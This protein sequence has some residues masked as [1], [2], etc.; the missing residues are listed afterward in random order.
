MAYKACVCT[1]LEH[2]ATSEGYLYLS[3]QNHLTLPCIVTRYV[4]IYR[5]P[6]I[7]RGMYISRLSM[8]LG[9]SRL[10]FRG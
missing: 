3:L 7:F 5:I 8:K 6:G 2:I 9:F 1:Y 10:K 4:P